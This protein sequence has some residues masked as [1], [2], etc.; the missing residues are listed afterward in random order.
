MEEVFK[1]RGVAYECEFYV[2]LDYG[3][4]GR[5]I[6]TMHHDPVT[7]DT[8][9]ERVRR[10]VE[11]SVTTSINGK[12]VRVRADSICVHSDTP[13]AVEV[14]RAVHRTLAERLAST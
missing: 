4:D 2:D 11:Q 5:Q 9:T 12:D 13:G 3:D 7:P 6:I 1:A 10:A 8:A 14:A